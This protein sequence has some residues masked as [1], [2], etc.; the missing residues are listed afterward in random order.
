LRIYVKQGGSGAFEAEWKTVGPANAGS[1]IQLRDVAITEFAVAGG[2][3]L[4]VGGG[5]ADAGGMLQRKFDSVVERGGLGQQGS[6]RE[7]EHR[8]QKFMNPRT[9]P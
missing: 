6:G 4:L 9:G 5:D 1:G 2:G 7:Y 3:V 8:Q